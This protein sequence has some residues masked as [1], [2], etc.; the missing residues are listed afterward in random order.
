MLELNL[1]R[2]SVRES[3]EDLGMESVMDLCSGW[4]IHPF[5]PRKTL[6]KFRSEDDLTEGLERIEEAI[7][8]TF[9]FENTLALWEPY[10]PKV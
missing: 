10:I 1:N 6:I 4:L 9:G 7:E 2:V 3:I 5:N 8:E